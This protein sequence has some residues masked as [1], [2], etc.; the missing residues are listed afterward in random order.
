MLF[1]SGTTAGPKA[2]LHTHNMR[3]SN[4]AFWAKDLGLRPEDRLICCSAFSHMWGI[5]NY[6]TGLV[7]GSGQVLLERYRP[8]A[9]ASAVS[10]GRATIAI[11][12]PVHVVDLLGAPETKPESLSSLRAF[13]LSGSVCPPELIRR[14]REALPGCVPIVF[15]GM[16]ET[17]GGF[18]TRPGDPPEVA[19]DT[20]GRASGACS[21]A[22]VDERGAAVPP[23]QEGELVIK[24]PFAID[25]YLNNPQATEE[26]FTKDGWFRTGDLA[27]ID[28]SGHV[29]ILGRRKEQINRGGV[30]YQPEDVES[31][32][33]RHPGV[34]MAALVGMP[35]ER[36]GER[37]VCFVVPRAGQKPPALGD[38]TGLL[39]KD[40]VA[41]FKWPERLEI[42]DALP[43]TPTGKVQR[44]A[45]RERLR[46]DK[47]H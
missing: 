44:G 46:T 35:D 6:L 14:M 20:A 42:V 18:Y 12:A 47:S 21:I 30:K 36:L 9:F 34:Q 19:E 17:G 39:E 40:G 22:V 25:R 11:G 16:T 24:S 3:L 1:T 15:W 33:L 8:A 7:A 38:L 23:G 28:A 10:E 31:V 13:A 4:S 37:G 43:M 26:S 41:K 45:L 32:L 27:R 29:R 5:F 2:T